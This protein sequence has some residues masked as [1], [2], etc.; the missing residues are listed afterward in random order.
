[1]IR[2]IL[3]IVDNAVHARPFVEAALAFA[4]M[5]GARLEIAVLTPGPYLAKQ[6]LPFGVAYLPEDALARDDRNKVEAVGALVAGAVS[7]VAVFGLHDDIAWLAGDVRRSRQLADIVLIG[8]E[9]HW[10][11]PWLRRRVVES[12]ILSSGT[13]TVI[14]PVDRRLVRLWLRRALLALV[15]APVA[16][17]SVRGI[18]PALAPSW[19]WLATAS[20]TAVVLLATA[21]LTRS[22]SAQ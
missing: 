3:A 9:A 20:L 19:L 6:I 17:L 18:D 14:L 7:P 1:M 11:T 8:S 4:E 10:E 2:D 13:P 15:P 12:S 21:R 16:W 5:R 22:E